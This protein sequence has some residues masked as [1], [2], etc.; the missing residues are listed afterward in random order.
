MSFAPA[1]HFAG[2]IGTRQCFTAASGTRQSAMSAT[3]LLNRRNVMTPLSA[4]NNGET[5]EVHPKE[6]T[7]KDVKTN[8]TYEMFVIVQSLSKQLNRVKIIQPRTVRFRVD[9]DNMGKIAAG[10]S[11]KLLV[12]FE[13]SL[14]DDYHDKFIVQYEKDGSKCDIEIPLHALRS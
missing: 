2:G 7:F 12:T 11:M 10:L 9:Y 8:Q 4:I 6:V 5:I 14:L 3:N 1:N 13:A